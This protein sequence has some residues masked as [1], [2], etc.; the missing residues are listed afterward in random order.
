MDARDRNN[1]QRYKRTDGRTDEET[2]RVRPSLRWSLTLSGSFRVHQIRFR[3][4]LRPWPHWGS[5]QRSPDP[6]GGLRCPILLRGG[7]GRRGESG[8]EREKKGTGGAAPPFGNSKIRPLSHCLIFYVNGGLIF[9]FVCSIKCWTEGI[10][11]GIRLL[12]SS[13]WPA[14]RLRYTLCCLR[15]RTWPLGGF[16]CTDTWTDVVPEPTLEQDGTVVD[17]AAWTL[18]VPT[19]LPWGHRSSSTIVALTSHCTASC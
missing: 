10:Q 17:S 6:L 13:I 8:E 18:P 9:S 2:R 16:R 15:P 4:G 7:E 5:L 11:H 3:P 14:W 19:P 12:W 1:G